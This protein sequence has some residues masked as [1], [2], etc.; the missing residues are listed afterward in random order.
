MVYGCLIDA[1]RSSDAGISP[2]STSTMQSNIK[3]KLGNWILFRRIGWIMPSIL[4]HGSGGKLKLVFKH[5]KQ[6]VCDHPVICCGWCG[7]R[8]SLVVPLRIEIGFSTCDGLPDHMAQ[9][10]LR[11]IVDSP[12]PMLLCIRYYMGVSAWRSCHYAVLKAAS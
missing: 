8:D 12:H 7:R 10:L 9:G 3:R 1:C 6:V 4:R 2:D 11:V 5:N